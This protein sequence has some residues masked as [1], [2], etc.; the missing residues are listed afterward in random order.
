MIGR[1][2]FSVKGDLKISD[3][4]PIVLD[5]VKFYFNTD[6]GILNEIVC[7]FKEIT[8]PEVGKRAGEN[9]ININS[10][11]ALS[12]IR[13]KLVVFQGITGVLS[14]VSIDFN[15]KLEW[16]PEEGESPPHLRAFQKSRGQ[17]KPVA[18]SFDLV[19]RALLEASEIS[20]DA[21]S[22]NFFRRA[23][24]DFEN[25]EFVSSFMN[26]FFMLERAFG[27]GRFK[28]NQLV[29]SF[30]SSPQLSG[31]ITRSRQQFL[32]MEMHRNDSFYQWL[33]KNDDARAVLWKIV[34]AR[35]SLFHNS[36]SGP[37]A[38]SPERQVALQP[39]SSYMLDICLEIGFGMTAPMYTADAK[40][41]YIEQAKKSGAM[42]VTRIFVDFIDEDGAPQQQHTDWTTPGNFLTNEIALQLVG[43]ALSK[44]TKTMPTKKLTRMVLATNEGKEL[45]KIEINV[46]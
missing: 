31:A 1:A 43:A 14:P 24:L 2:I 18:L 44:F 17:L 37:S 12:N 34:E 27:R 28:K 33:L 16:Y 7:E 30:A 8:P 15:P 42:T 20:N 19:A 11:H 6:G 46:Q 3:H 32:K 35:G 9:Y 21:I 13:Q 23:R 41:R 10:S 38:W 5:G 39:I 4:F 26:A 29:E 36:V 45:A 22:L 40:N 25:E